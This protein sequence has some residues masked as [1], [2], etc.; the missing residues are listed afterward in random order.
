MAKSLVGTKSHENLKH[1]FAGESQAQNWLKPTGRV[2]SSRQSYPTRGV[3]GHLATAG[4]LWYL[5]T[6]FIMI[7]RS[8][9][10]ILVIPQ[11]GR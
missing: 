4:L 2:D 9:S 8:L 5:P 6:L 1:A 7:K 11:A 10:L 3:Q